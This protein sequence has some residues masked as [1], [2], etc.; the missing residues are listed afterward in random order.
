[1]WWCVWAEQA[2]IVGA[3]HEDTSNTQQRKG[4]KKAGATITGEK[5]ALGRAASQHD[6]KVGT[7]IAQA[8]PWALQRTSHND[9]RPRT[10]GESTRCLVGDAGAILS[11]PTTAHSCDYSS[12]WR[13]RSPQDLHSQEG[14]VHMEPTQ[15]SANLRSQCFAL[16]SPQRRLGMIVIRAYL[17]IFKQNEA[18]LTTSS[19][20]APLPL[21]VHSVDDA[22]KLAS[23]FWWKVIPLRER[24]WCVARRA[25][26][27]HKRCRIVRG[28]S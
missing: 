1:M 20:E 25:C 13:T 19:T 17:Q 18:T 28:Q 16:Q 24:L 27:K 4:A 6:H 21:Q 2:Q 26:R 3:L 9:G 8:Q 23:T 7:P 12:F 14:A 15:I 11:P 5:R 10:P 22:H